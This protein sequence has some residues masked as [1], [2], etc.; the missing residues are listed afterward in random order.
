MAIDLFTKP[1]KFDGDWDNRPAVK[2]L[3]FDLVNRYKEFRGLFFKPELHAAL[4]VIFEDNETAHVPESVIHFRGF[5]KWHKDTTTQDIAGRK[6][7]YE[8]D[9]LMVECA[10]YLQDNTPKYGGGLDVIPGT[11]KEPYDRYV[12][13]K[14]KPRNIFCPGV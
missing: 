6:F 7:H 2:A 12:E 3:R 1:V 14:G 8:P 11:H 4:K 13:P 10:I 5:G 9:W